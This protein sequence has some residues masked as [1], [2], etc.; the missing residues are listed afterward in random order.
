[1]REITSVREKLRIII[2]HKK[3]KFFVILA[4]RE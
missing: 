1:M 4:G 2:F 3:H